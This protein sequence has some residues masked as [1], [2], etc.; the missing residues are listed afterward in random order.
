MT[1]AE[2]TAEKTVLL[3]DDDVDF[4]TQMELQLQAAGYRVL[5]AGSVGAA[6]EVLD[7]CRPDVAVLDLMMENLD[8]GFVLAHR[9]KSG[10]QP[11]PVILVTAV[12]S[13]T[14]FQFDTDSDE[15]RSWIKADAMLNKPVRLEQLQREIKRLTE[16]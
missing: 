10:E 16:E 3:V 4:L 8:D 15:A 12:T 2:N 6:Q 9:I 5:T 11:M 7:D 1:A 14:G 13:E